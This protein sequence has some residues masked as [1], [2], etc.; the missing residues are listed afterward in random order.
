MAHFVNAS[1]IAEMTHALGFTA[2]TL[3]LEQVTQAA[4]EAIAARLG[5]TIVSEANTQ[6]GFAGLCVGFGPAEDGQACPEPLSF[7]D[8][9]SDWMHGEVKEKQGDPPTLFAR[10][11]WEEAREETPTD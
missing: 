7:Y 10:A 6:P 4:A 3:A 5:V 9:G 11:P 2:L 8:E 1:E